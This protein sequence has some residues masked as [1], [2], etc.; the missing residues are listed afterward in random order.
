MEED[1]AGF[2]DKIWGGSIMKGAFFPLLSRMKFINRWSLMR[3]ARE[4]N[5]MEHSFETAVLA[6][7]LAIIGRRVYNK[8]CDPSTVAAYALY[9]DCAEIITGDM[10]TPVKYEN[11]QIREAYKRVEAKA[12]DRLFDMIPKELTEDFEPAIY[13]EEKNPELYR[14][15]K[16]ADKISAYIKC[17]EE[18]NAGNRDFEGAEEQLRE[19][20]KALNMPEADYYME[21]FVHFYGKTLDELTK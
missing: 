16:A 10:P 14:Y 1:G 11:S 6:H 18:K 2:K 21:N 8:D 15:I 20:V 9:H 19:A 3:N 17:L 5:L 12:K 13:C 4:E 7:T